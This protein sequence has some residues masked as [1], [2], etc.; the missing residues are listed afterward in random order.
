VA[1]EVPLSPDCKGEGSVTG[2]IGDLKDGDRAAMEPLWDRYF[3]RLAALARKRLRDSPRAGAVD[4]EDVALSALNSLWDRIST[5]QLPD[6][7]GRDELWRLLVVIAARKVI[8]HIRHEG[9]QKRGGGRVVNEAVLAAAD[10][11]DADALAR[12]V[13]AEPTPEFVAMVAEETA[14]RLDSLPDPM[15][16]QVAVLRME[17]HSNAEVA[18]RLGCVVRTVERKLDVIRS[19]WGD[20][21]AP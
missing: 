2:W 9:R 20:E 15:L 7:R 21:A 17:G 10:G 11:S 14:R 19:L 16:R 5:G 3:R 18:E 4:E 8:G 1:A 6:V 13:A 12:F